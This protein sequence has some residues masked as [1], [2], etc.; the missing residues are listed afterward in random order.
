MTNDILKPSDGNIHGWSFVL[1]EEAD[2][3]VGL[4]V[5]LEGG[6]HHKVGSRRQSEAFRDLPHVDVG[7]A[8]SFRGV[9][10]EEVLSLLVFIIWS[11]WAHHT[12]GV[13]VQC[14]RKLFAHLLIIRNL[15][16]H[17]WQSR[18]S[19]CRAPPSGGDAGSSAWE[20]R[21]RCTYGHPHQ[22]PS[23]ESWTGGSTRTCLGNYI[24]C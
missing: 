3:E 20:P 1:W 17:K 10:P 7:T 19:P 6:G 4:V 13:S 9:V 11:L 24:G 12:S 22:G 18:W 21:W 8:A 15:L 23:D 2:E 16:P 5:G 14:C